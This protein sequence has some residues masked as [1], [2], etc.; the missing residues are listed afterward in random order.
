MKILLTGGA[1]YIG[2]QISYDLTDRGNDVY[3]VDNL[4]TGSLISINKKAK[5]YICFNLCR[6]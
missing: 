6:L 3:I 1:G 5:F 2:S 4:E